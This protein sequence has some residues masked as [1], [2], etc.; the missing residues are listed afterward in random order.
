MRV[1]TAL[2]PGL[3]EAAY[4]TCLAREL[5]IRG[6]DVLRQVGV[7]VTYDGVRINAGYRIDLLVDDTVVV[8]VKS[9]AHFDRIHE[10]QLLTYLCLSGHPVGLLINFLRPSSSRRNHAS[11]RYSPTGPG[12]SATE[13]PHSA[14]LSRN[15]AELCVERMRGELS[16]EG[17][18]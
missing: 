1:R 3:H 18:R 8:E 16:I 6:H 2:G 15:S 10:A 7:P 9:V 12:M 11:G 17:G 5:S 4:E 14:V 13:S